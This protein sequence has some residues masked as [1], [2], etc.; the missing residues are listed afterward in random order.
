MTATTYDSYNTRPHWAGASRDTDI[1]LEIYNNDIESAFLYNSV[2]RSMTDFRPVQGR[3]NTY[4]G[5][6]VGGMTVSGRTAGVALTTT[7]TKSEK[8]NLTVEVVSY[9]Q[10]SVDFQDDWTAP[11]FRTVYTR[12]AGIAQAK[13][14][15]QAHIIQ[16]MKAGDFSAPATLSGA[17][18]NGILKKVVVGGVDSEADAEAWVRGHA[19]AVDDLVNRDVDLTT[20][21]TMCSTNVFSTLLHHEKLMNVQFSPNVDNS[22]AARRIA[23]LNGVRLM[24]TARFPTSGTAVSG[25]ILSTTAN[26]NAFDL[27]ASQSKRQMVIFDTMNALITVEAKPFTTDIVPLPQEFT[28]LLQTYHMYTVGCVR[29]DAVAVVSTEV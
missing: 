8:Y 27:T 17:F 28:T 23:M 25:H 11:D 20:Y 1:H 13:A 7:P 12:N 29:P 18:S 21:V 16:L 19:A 14:F 2:F 9:T 3:S 26:S 24:E 5:D 22:F 15:D 6:R 4:R 10:N